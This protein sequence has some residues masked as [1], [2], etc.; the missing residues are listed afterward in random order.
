MKHVGYDTNT[1]RK[2]V[3]VFRE[4][5]EDSQNALVVE[6]AKLSERYHDGLMSA[7]ESSEAQSTND[8]Y[9]VLDRKLFFDGENILKTLHLKGNLKKVPTESIILSPAPGKNISLSE[10]NTQLG[11]VVIPEQPEGRPSDHDPDAEKKE[12]LGQAKNLIIQAQLLEE[13]ARKK[14]AE[15]ESIYPGINEETKRPRGRPKKDAPVSP[16]MEQTE[17]QSS[18]A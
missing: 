14:R 2:Y 13:D 4:L 18:S 7:V 10:Y 1:K 6:T 12:L 3:V 16:L 17:E 9:S 5:P 11:S 15:A 8:L